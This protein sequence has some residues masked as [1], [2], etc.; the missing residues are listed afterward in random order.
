MTVGFVRLI[1]RSATR[2]FF[3]RDGGR[4]VVTLL[5]Y[6]WKSFAFVVATRVLFVRGGGQKHGQPLQLAAARFY[7][8]VILLV[9]I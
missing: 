7:A 1:I 9:V 8:L 3:V 4:N 2:L 6:L 5:V